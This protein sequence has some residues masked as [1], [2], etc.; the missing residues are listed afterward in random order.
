[1]FA[2]YRMWYLPRYRVANS[3]CSAE[4]AAPEWRPTDHIFRGRSQQEVQKKADKLWREAQFGSGSMLCVP[5][6]EDLRATLSKQEG[7]S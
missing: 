4:F 5:A 1:M 2:D 3:G 7:E 6:D